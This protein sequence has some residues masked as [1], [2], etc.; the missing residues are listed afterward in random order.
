[1]VETT[2][3]LIIIMKEEVIHGIMTQ[4]LLGEIVGVEIVIEVETEVEIKV[5][6]EVEME[7]ETGGG[8]HR[9]M[10]MIE[11]RRE[12]GGTEI[13]GGI[14]R[15]G[16]MEIMGGMQREGG[17]MSEGGKKIEGGKMRGVGREG[18]GE[19]VTTDMKMK[20]RRIRETELAV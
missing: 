16:G 14:G 8:G 4:D 17:K 12:G 1:M 7:E 9:V 20:V 13:E 19:M 18:V 6:M 11:E 5:E 2:G 3:D 15:V 10:R